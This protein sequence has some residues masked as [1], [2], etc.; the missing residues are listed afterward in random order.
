MS[1]GICV[2]IEGMWTFSVTLVLGIYL[3]FSVSSSP[4]Y[5]TLCNIGGKNSSMPYVAY[6]SILMFFN[7]R[8]TF[9]K[10]P[11]NERK[12]K[13]RKKE[14]RMKTRGPARSVWARNV[15]HPIIIAELITGHIP[16]SS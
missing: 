8:K 14:E 1:H 11:K 12:I 2:F 13:K 7:I 4:M 6:S 9:Q 16:C 15:P 10:S 3:S 5:L